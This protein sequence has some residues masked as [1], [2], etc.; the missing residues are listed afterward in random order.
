VIRESIYE[1]EIK[2]YPNKIQLSA[3][4]MAVYY[5]VGGKKPIP[6]KY[7]NER[8]VFND[9]GFL[10]DIVTGD[11]VIANPKVAGKPRMWNVNFQAIWN[12]AIKHQQRAVIT[13]KLK[14]LLVPH[15]ENLIPIKEYPIG[16]EMFIIDTE[17]KVD[18]HNKSVI[19]HK[20][21]HDLLVKPYVGE[22]E[23][24]TPAIIPDDNAEHINDSGRLKFIRTSSLDEVRMVIRIYKSD[25]ELW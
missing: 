17:M 11:R 8:Y 3:K 13:N 20:V 6:K 5:R 16:V 22:N 10:E 24:N 25:D 15:V 12:Q 14:E 4:R 19:Y 9:K 1:I 7:L 23:K 21:F 18:V 2:D